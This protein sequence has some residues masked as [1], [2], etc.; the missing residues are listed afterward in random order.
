MP[1]SDF[2]PQ[3]DDNTHAVAFVVGRLARFLWRHTGEELDKTAV[4]NL[5]QELIGSIPPRSTEPEMLHY[6]GLWVQA[7]ARRDAVY[8]RRAACVLVGLFFDCGPDGHW[9]PNAVKEGPG[10]QRLPSLRDLPPFHNADDSSIGI[11]DAVIVDCESR[12][13]YIGLLE[14]PKPTERGFSMLI[15]GHSH[16]SFTDGNRFVAAAA[17]S[18]LAGCECKL[19]SGHEANW[20]IREPKPYAKDG[21]ESTGLAEVLANTLLYDPSWA[22]TRAEKVPFVGILAFKIIDSGGDPAVKECYYRVLRSDETLSR[23]TTARADYELG[24]EALDPP[25]WARRS[26]A[27]SACNYRYFDKPDDAVGDAMD[28]DQAPDVRVKL[29]PGDHPPLVSSLD[30]SQLFTDHAFGRRGMAA[31]QPGDRAYLSLHQTNSWPKGINS[32]KGQPVEVTHAVLREA[33]TPSERAP[34]SLLQVPNTLKAVPA[35]TNERPPVHQLATPQHGFVV[36]P[37]FDVPEKGG[38][39][40]VD[41]LVAFIFFVARMLQTGLQSKTLFGLE[42]LQG[43]GKTLLLQYILCGILGPNCARY[44]RNLAN[45][46]IKDFFQEHI[47]T[48]ALVT[49]ELDQSVLD[50]NEFKAL[51]DDKTGTLQRKHINGIERF[52]SFF[53]LWAAWNP[54]SKNYLQKVLE[55]VPDRGRR[56]VAVAVSSTLVSQGKGRKPGGSAAAR[57]IRTF[58][59][60]QANPWINS[61][62]HNFLMTEVEAGPS[63]NLQIFGGDSQD[64][65]ARLRCILF[66]GELSLWDQFLNFW[67]SLPEAQLPAVGVPV[68]L[69]GGEGSP[70]EGIFDVCLTDMLAVVKH[71]LFQSKENGLLNMKP[72]KASKSVGEGLSVALLIGIEEHGWQ[73]GISIPANLLKQVIDCWYRHRHPHLEGKAKTTVAAGIL[74]ELVAKRI[75]T[76]ETD[77]S[78]RFERSAIATQMK[79]VGIAPPPLAHAWYDRV[80]SKNNKKLLADWWG[81][82]ADFRG[83]SARSFPVVFALAVKDKGAAAPAV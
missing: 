21:A 50:S 53:T 1:Q 40:W 77:G 39:I 34:S 49:D 55:G 19:V 82:S 17:A 22:N 32:S 6:A 73:D 27:N 36:T 13:H 47:N 2:P 9:W 4:N 59:A 72:V 23:E 74:K 37:V 62:F 80:Q 58:L 71:G 8:R 66:D 52:V 5:V 81:H 28:V 41:G 33:L 69:V 30:F 42:G 10:G 54:K 68:L 65:I 38:Q 78:F 14:V 83:P 45:L 7:D 20:T 26:G 24:A 46:M 60:N 15:G 25:P 35:P 16:C 48:L 63:F 12:G 57:Y 75:L 43:C 76:A 3:G 51:C 11:L 67:V 70:V 61:A 29:S 31:L 18:A 79:A 56:V 44:V 64:E